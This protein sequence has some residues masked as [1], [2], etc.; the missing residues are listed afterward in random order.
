MA[1][2][3][4]NHCRYHPYA[5]S[6]QIS[7]SDFPPLQHRHPHPVQLYP[8]THP[9]AVMVRPSF[10][11]QR[12]QTSIPRHE[13]SRPHQRHQRTYSYLGMPLD[14]AFERL[15]STG[16][17]VPLAPRPSP[18]ILPSRF[19]LMSSVHF[20]R[21]RATV[22]IIVLLC[23][24]PYRILLTVVQLAFPYRLQTLILVQICPL[25]PFQLSPHMQFLLLRAYTI[26][27]WTP[28]ALIF[29]RH[30]DIA[31][32]V[33]HIEIRLLQLRFTMSDEITP[34]T[35]TALYE[36][37]VD[38]TR[39][40]E[41]IELILSGHPS[42][43]RGAPRVAMP[44]LPHLTSSTPA[45]LGASH[46]RSRPHSVFQQHSSSISLATP[47]RPPPQFRGPP[48]VTVPHDRFPPHRRCRRHFSDLSAPLS[49]VFEMFQA[50][51]FLA[52]LAPRALPDPVPPQF[53]LDLYC[54][55]HQSVGHHT[56][57]CTALRHAIQDIVD[58]GTFGHPQS[59]MSLISTPAQAMHAETPSP[60]VPDLIDLGD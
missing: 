10:Q 11:F 7:R 40:V 34:I 31:Y 19:V 21:W 39:R 32:L 2:P 51:G 25:I 33:E 43:S 17:L 37:M 48:V 14:R 60:A 1:T 52:P 13:Q 16:V 57:R 49:R 44:S 56:D 54:A 4:G 6:L 3:L 30:F 46:P 41:R 9:H 18:S 8:S 36:M 29:T 35:L 22:L 15:R 58:S 23:V 20:T 47:T 5:R 38:L 27:F 28:R 26:T 53:G 59:D 55:Y 12:P 50:M 45:T 24:T 42:S